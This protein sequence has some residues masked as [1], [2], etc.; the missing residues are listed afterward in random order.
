MIKDCGNSNSNIWSNIFPRD[1]YSIK[2]ILES[3]L[4]LNNCDIALR[5]VNETFLKVQRILWAEF[6]SRIQTSPIFFNT[7]I[8]KVIYSR[9][10]SFLWISLILFEPFLFRCWKSSNFLI[11]SGLSSD[12]LIITST[13]RTAAVSSYFFL[14]MEQLNVLNGNYFGI[15]KQRE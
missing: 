4:S 2:N 6:S 14:W 11:K 12:S 13:Q 8:W 10:I 9:N 5:K 3:L 1:V 15:S 7:K